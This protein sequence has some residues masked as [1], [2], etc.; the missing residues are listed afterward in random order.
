MVTAC[1]L[2]VDQFHAV[3]KNCMKPFKGIHMDQLELNKHSSN[4]QV[5]I[6]MARNLIECVETFTAKKKRI[7][8]Q[9]GRSSTMLDS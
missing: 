4:I 9:R 8:R 1:Y 3:L 6:H 2:A 5:R 7:G